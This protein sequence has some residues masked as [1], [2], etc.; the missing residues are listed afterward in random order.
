MVQVC[1]RFR[2]TVR[3]IETTLTD[4]LR[5]RGIPLPRTVRQRFREVVHRHLPSAVYYLAAFD[6]LIRT[7]RPEVSVVTN[8]TGY[9]G[10]AAVAA[11]RGASTRS[12]GVQHGLI[13]RHHIEYVNDAL[14]MDRRNPWSCPWPDLTAL[15]G[16]FYESVLTRVGA[17]PKD[18]TVVT[19]QMRY[20]AT[21]RNGGMS[22]REERPSILVATHPFE[23]GRWIAHVLEA[24][25]ELGGLKIKP[26]PL[27]DPGF[28]ERV[29]RTA[30]EARVIREGDVMS[31]LGSASVLVTG[32]ST[33][34]VEAA[35]AG[36][37]AVL[38]N[39]FGTP[40]AIPF[41][42]LGGAIRAESVGDLR[43]AVSQV[44]EGG[45]VLQKLEQGRDS[46]LG[47]FAF[48]GSTGCASRLADAILR[49]PSALPA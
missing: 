26:H 1:R 49:S 43:T 45:D 3:E 2:R 7:W 4:S 20:E 48:G 35:L 9:A 13:T 34:I 17:Y 40:E 11:C 15:D 38:F 28:Y 33:T 6:E 47:A 24:C 25:K 14:S 42:E 31:L 19:G 23:R 27:E 22:L 29:A 8:E 46:F 18:A 5:W 21:R 39:P 36:C 32:F 12:V 30:R 10:R 41:T 37:P 16:T 44:L